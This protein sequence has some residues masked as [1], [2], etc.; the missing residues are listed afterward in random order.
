LFNGPLFGKVNLNA[1]M[2]T[3]Q[4]ELIGSIILFSVYSLLG[5]R[6]PAVT[7]L[8]FM[9]LSVV[10]FPSS[11]YQLH[12]LTIFAGSM[13][14]Y[15]ERFLR[16]SLV[17]PPL[18]I[19]VGVLFSAYDFSPW[20][21]WARLTMPELAAPLFNP[22]GSERYVFNA[23]GA[24]LLV[25]GIL[26]NAASAR[27][28]ASRLPVYLGKIS[29]SLYLLHWPIICS[30]SFGM[31]YLLKVRMG[32]D[33][34]QALGMTAIGT[35]ILTLGVAHLFEAVI[36][37]PAILIAKVISKYILGPEQVAGGADIIRSRRTRSCPSDNPTGIHTVLPRR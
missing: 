33:Y 36:D 7:T 22:V 30:L 10:V 21:D 20:Y 31:M 12:V 26:G 9:S 29:F 15:V 14:H 11:I 3:I 19:A 16:R 25:G 35:I 34:L 13:L 24:V 8:L 28:L 17:V 18:L 23:V 5:K 1:P 32:I 4:I 2:W 6:R 37:R 27:I